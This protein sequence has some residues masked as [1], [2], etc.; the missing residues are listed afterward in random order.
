M[1]NSSLRNRGELIRVTTASR[2]I[3]SSSAAATKRAGVQQ[4]NRT[5]GGCVRVYMIIIRKYLGGEMISKVEIWG[6][7]YGLYLII[8]IVLHIYIYIYIF[9]YTFQYNAIG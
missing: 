4:T 7:L 9:L 6:N 2:R 3:Y 1:V 5:F 8:L